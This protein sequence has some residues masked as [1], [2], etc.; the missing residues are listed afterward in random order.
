M[1]GDLVRPSSNEPTKP[2]RWPRTGAE[3]GEV[4]TAGLGDPTSS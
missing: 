2:D 1:A 3:Q 4:R